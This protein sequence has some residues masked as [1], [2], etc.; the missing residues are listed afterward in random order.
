MN[1]E[2]FE[3]DNLEVPSGQGA[4]RRGPCWAGLQEFGFYSNHKGKPL[5]GFKHESYVI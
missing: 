3:L 5:E 1:L 4:E 2:G